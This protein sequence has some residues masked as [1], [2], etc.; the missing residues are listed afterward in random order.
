MAISALVNS[1]TNA[2]PI[3]I[4]LVASS[5]TR[6]ESIASAMTLHECSRISGTIAFILFGSNVIELM[7]ARPLCSRSAASI[8]RGFGLSRERGASTAA[9]TV[10][11]SHERHSGSFSRNMPAFTSI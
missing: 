9:C 10:L 2:V 7:I 11:T 8:A 6:T 5:G 3:S 4:F 1:S